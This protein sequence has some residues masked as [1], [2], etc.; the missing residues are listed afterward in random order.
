MERCP[1]CNA[2]HRGE[3]QCHRCGMDLS[4]L[5]AIEAQ[6]I[7]WE[8]QALMRLRT[9][10]AAGAQEASQRAL[11]LQQRELAALL[12]GFAK[13]LLAEQHPVHRTSAEPG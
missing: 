5:L 10:D 8:Q 1:N 11:D 13:W 2:R 4:T 9:G 12:Q 7:Y 3:A 6:A